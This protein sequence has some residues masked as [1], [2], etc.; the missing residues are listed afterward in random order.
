M[1]LPIGLAVLRARVFPQ[2][3]LATAVD[4]SVFIQSGHQSGTKVVLRSGTTTFGRSSANHVQLLDREMS[5]QHFAIVLESDAVWLRDLGSVN[6]TFVNGTRTNYRQLE[7][8][9]VIR[10]GQIELLFT[11]GRNVGEAAALPGLSVQLVREVETNGLPAPFSDESGRTEP[12]ALPPK[13]A[14]EVEAGSRGDLDFLHEALQSLGSGLSVDELFARI[15]ERIFSWVNV[16]RA[17]VVLGGKGGEEFVVTAAR[18]R[19]PSSDSTMKVSRTI[20][21]YV[22]SRNVGVLTHDARDDS[23]WDDSDPS[24]AVGIHEAICVPLLGRSELLGAIYVDTFLRPGGPRSASGRLLKEEHLQTMLAV[25]RLA[26]LALENARYSEELLAKA[27]LAAIGETIASL[28]H[29]IKNILQ[30]MSSGTYLL[31]QGLQNQSQ[32]DTHRGWEIVRRYQ[33]SISR[34][35]LDMLSYSRERR[36]D[37]VIADL[38]RTVAECVELMRSRADNAGVELIWEPAGKLA[39]FEFDPFGLSHAVTNLLQNAIDASEGK[40]PG[41]VRVTVLDERENG[42][43]RIVVQDNGTGIPATDL[44]RIFELFHSTK[45]NKGTGLGLAVS[46]KIVEEHGGLITVDSVLGSG[47][48][49]TIQ[50]PTDCRHE[51]DAVNRETVEG[52]QLQPKFQPAKNSRD[53]CNLPRAE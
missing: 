46:R 51:T 27:K 47:S 14:L 32:E 16:D 19:E 37:W 45:G 10:A 34:L 13:L 20:L 25:G 12:L 53:A 9:D 8:G 1:V 15:L 23:R 40:A 35:V 22:Q 26:G 49:F 48:K 11:S 50:L 38:N 18:L 21:R 17:C 4:S 5:R 24:S 42:R 7:T 44:G 33:D 36:P 43:A 41:R 52:T 29:H 3:K 2:Q 31:E 6:G 30:G 39:N 28:S